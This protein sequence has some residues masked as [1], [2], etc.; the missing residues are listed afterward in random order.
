[1]RDTTSYHVV[2]YAECNA[3]EHASI[4]H[5]FSSCAATLHSNTFSKPR[6]LGLGAGGGYLLR[7][8]HVLM[9]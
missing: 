8:L 4:E 9:H 7:P 1:M 5:V 2:T 3:F 6:R